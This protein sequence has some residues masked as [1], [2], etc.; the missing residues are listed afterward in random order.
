VPGDVVDDDGGGGV[1]PGG[2]LIGG[3]VV[4]G[5]AEGEMPLGDTVIGTDC[6]D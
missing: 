5:I 2:T 4:L 3:S 6:G 1:V